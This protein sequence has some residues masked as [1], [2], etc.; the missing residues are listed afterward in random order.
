MALRF[1][2]VWSALPVHEGKFL[3]VLLE[4]CHLSLH[5][6]QACGCHILAKRFKLILQAMFR[7]QHSIDRMLDDCITLRMAS[8][9][10]PLLEQCAVFPVCQASF[11]S[12]TP[13]HFCDCW[14]R[15]CSPHTLNVS[16]RDGDPSYQSRSVLVHSLTCCTYPGYCAHEQVAAKPSFACMDK[17]GL[18]QVKEP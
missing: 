13:H 5:V 2:S 6:L 1:S 15:A 16:Y 8:M 3:Q 17:L 7:F 10:L 9:C 4:G 11:S 12:V 18:R 14:Y